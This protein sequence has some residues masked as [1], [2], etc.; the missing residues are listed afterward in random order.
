MIRLRYVDN[1]AVMRLPAR[2]KSAATDRQ[3]NTVTDEYVMR[4]YVKRPCAFLAL[5][6]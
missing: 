1:K 5:V 6:A 2:N 4:I 3:L